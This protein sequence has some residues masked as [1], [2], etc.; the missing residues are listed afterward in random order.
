MMPSA[1]TGP[2]AARDA[3]RKLLGL[4]P[5]PRLRCAGG[6]LGGFPA[7]SVVIPT[8]NEEKMIGGL[9]DHLRR[10]AP[11]EIIVAD[12][13][14]TDATAEIAQPHA[15]V[16][17]LAPSRALQMNAGAKAATG[18][19]LLFLH[20]DARLGP[21]ALKAVR[22]AMRD[23]AVLGGNFDIHYEGEDWAA[24]FFTTI[25]RWRRH[26][27]IFYGDSGIFCRRA[28]FEALGGYRPWPILEDYDFARRLWRTGALALLNE[29]IH[30]SDRRWRN[31]GV[32]STLWTWFW[33]QGLYL[34]GVSPYRLA[35]LYRHVR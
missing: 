3:L 22:E 7:I 34:A 9:L 31:S 1:R 29:P 35:K 12:G 2:V 14:S 19:V 4:K 30:V 18:D 8:Y 27:G 33:V 6:L 10:L 23:K 21:G 32:L 11:E 17:R 26:W 24:A 25:N 28:A 20:A 13:N 16:L 5:R 15:R